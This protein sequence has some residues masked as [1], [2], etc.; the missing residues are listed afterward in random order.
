MCQKHVSP[1]VRVTE[2]PEAGHRRSIVL[3]VRVSLLADPSHFISALLHFARQHCDAEVLPLLISEQHYYGCMNA[4]R[5]RLGENMAKGA[6]SENEPG[7][8]LGAAA[9]LVVQQFLQN[10]LVSLRGET[11]QIELLREKPGTTVSLNGEYRLKFTTLYNCELY[12]GDTLITEFDALVINP[13]GMHI[14][15]VCAS[16]VRVHEKLTNR[17]QHYSDV[18]RAFAVPGNTFHLETVHILTES[19]VAGTVEQ[20][21]G[22][23]V[24]LPLFRQVVQVS[25]AF[26]AGRAQ[27]GFHTFVQHLSSRG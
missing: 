11:A 23:V 17:R 21:N 1:L 13:Q 3:S 24:S 9:E 8:I 25:E 22:F 4:L 2:K 12:H 15:D 14:I 10:M 16:R 18:S 26:C 6:L 7:R 27:G 19:G 20:A 5:M